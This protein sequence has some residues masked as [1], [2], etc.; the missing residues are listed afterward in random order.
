MLAHLS[1]LLSTL[2]LLGQLSTIVLRVL[3]NL[4][5]GVLDRLRR[6][7]QGLVVPLHFKKDSV[8]PFLQGQMTGLRLDW[9]SG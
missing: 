9:R 4:M 2:Y 1:L 7:N 6:W 5:I 8:S 3:F